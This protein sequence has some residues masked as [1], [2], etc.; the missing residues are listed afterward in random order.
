MTIFEFEIFPN[1]PRNPGPRITVSQTPKPEA[2]PGGANFEIVI[3][4]ESA[5]S[6]GGDYE[7]EVDADCT[8]PG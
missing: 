3:V 2:I 7:T 1:P 5:F 6:I 8:G 4:R